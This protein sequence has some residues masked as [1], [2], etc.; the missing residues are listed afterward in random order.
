MAYD[1]AAREVLLLATTAFKLMRYADLATAPTILDIPTFVALGANPRMAINPIDG[2]VWVSS[3]ASSTLYGLSEATGGGPMNVEFLNHPL[4]V[5]PGGLDFDDRGHLFVATGGVIVEM[6]LIVGGG[7]QP[8]A[9]PLFSTATASGLFH[10]AR[11]RTNATA[12][13]DGPAW[14]NIPHGERVVIGELVSDCY[15]DLDGDGQVGINDFLMVLALWGPCD[16]D[17]VADLD[18]DEEVGITDFLGVL[19]A[20]GPCP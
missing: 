3:D 6:E 16:G 15:A 10:V 4:I 18:H 11:S 2:K 1:D 9:A 8:V 19:A 20:W 5:S 12:L 17:C 14:R 13:H 7:W